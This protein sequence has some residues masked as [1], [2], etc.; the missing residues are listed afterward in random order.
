MGV[1]LYYAMFYAA[2][3]LL[4]SQNVTAKSHTGLIQVFGKHLINPGLLEPKFGRKLSNAF[5]LRLDSDYNI[6]LTPDA[7]L[8][9]DILHD[10]REFV[11]RAEQYLRREGWL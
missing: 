9:E 8:A 4:G 7:A 2:T 3:A 5:Q 11:D 6:T 1:S 10:A